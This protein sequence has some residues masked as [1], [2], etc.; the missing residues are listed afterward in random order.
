MG[1]IYGKNPQYVVDGT[2]CDNCGTNLRNHDFG[3]MSKECVCPYMF[4]DELV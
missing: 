3:D 1:S 2:L 4:L